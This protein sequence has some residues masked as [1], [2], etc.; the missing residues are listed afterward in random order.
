[1]FPR[2]AIEKS[3]SAVQDSL[4][5]L[6]IERTDMLRHIGLNPLSVVHILLEDLC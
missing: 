1:M 6:E 2:I 4:V 5:K 3:E